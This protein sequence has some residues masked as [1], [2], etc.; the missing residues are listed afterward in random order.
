MINVEAFDQ[1]EVRVG[2]VTEVKPNKKSRNPSYV[3][4]IDF[5]PELGVKKIL[6]ADHRPLHPGR[7]DRNPGGVLCESGAHADRVCQK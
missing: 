7:P 5:G 3:V 2:T 6:S 1:V 4:T